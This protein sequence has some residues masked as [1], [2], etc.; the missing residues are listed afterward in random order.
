MIFHCK[1]CKKDFKKRIKGYLNWKCPKC[2]EI[3]PKKGFN[4]FFKGCDTIKH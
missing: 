4:L 3:S 1:K 2:G